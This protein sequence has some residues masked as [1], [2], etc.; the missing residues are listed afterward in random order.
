MKWKKISITEDEKFKNSTLTKK[1]KTHCLN[2]MKQ[3]FIF[4]IDFIISGITGI[5]V[6]TIYFVNICN[7]FD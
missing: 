2:L 3:E 5:R 4:L 7:I 6:I 1:K